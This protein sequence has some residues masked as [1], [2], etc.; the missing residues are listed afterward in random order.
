MAAGA[1]GVD[2]GAGVSA[3]IG[4]VDELELLELMLWRL[5]S[6]H[7]GTG[8]GVNSER[9]AGAVLLAAGSAAEWGSSCEQEWVMALGCGRARAIGAARAVAG[10]SAAVAAVADA[11][12][13]GTAALVERGQLSPALRF[14]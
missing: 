8:S 9:T 7:A 14:R 1:S 3:G 5:R 10:A 4:G 13:F 12:A 11:R 2:N 6:R